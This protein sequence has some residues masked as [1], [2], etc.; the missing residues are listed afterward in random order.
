MSALHSVLPGLVEGMMSKEVETVQIDKA[1]QEEKS[2]N[3]L[4]ETSDEGTGVYA[5][6]LNK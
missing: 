3:N 1:P 6:R 4:Q 2:S 5:G